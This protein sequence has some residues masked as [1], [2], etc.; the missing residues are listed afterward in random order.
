MMYVRIM[1]RMIIYDNL[2]IEGSLLYAPESRTKNYINTA[3]TAPH[4]DTQQQKY[5]L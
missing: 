4:A 1:V 3:T 2:L 5:I